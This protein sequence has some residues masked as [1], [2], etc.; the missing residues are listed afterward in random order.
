MRKKTVTSK[1]PAEEVI[2]DIRRATRRHF[3]AEEKIRIVL[4]GLRGEESFSSVA[5]LHGVAPNLL[6]RWRRLMT[7]GGAVA[8]DADN[9]VT[10][11]LDVRKLEERVRAPLHSCVFEDL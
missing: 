2:R 6:Y 7:E 3:S 5:R 11:N 1:Q 10:R 4:E 8:V 9:Q